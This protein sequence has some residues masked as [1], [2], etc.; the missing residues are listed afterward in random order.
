MLN[1]ASPTDPIM[2]ALRYNAIRRISIPGDSL[3]LDI[4]RPLPQ[5]LGIYTLPR[6]GASDED[7]LTLVVGNTLGLQID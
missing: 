2:R 4:A 5:N 1:R 7:H 6:Q 3:R